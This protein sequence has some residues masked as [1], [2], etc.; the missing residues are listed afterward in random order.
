PLM[1]APQMPTDVVTDAVPQPHRALYRRFRAQRFAEVIGQDPI[2]TTLRRAIASDR[3]AHAYLFVGPRGTGKTSTARILAK[4][5]NCTALAEDG[6]PCDAC[7]SC[8]SIRD[9][10]ALDVIEIDAASHGLVEDARDLVMR[11]LTAPSELRKRVYII[12]EVHMLSTHA[13]N[14]LLKLIEEPPDHVVFIL[15]T[16]DTHK[17]PPTIISRTQRHDF[18]RLAD[19]IIAGK[20]ARIC[21]TEGVEADADALDLVARLADGGMRDAESILDQVLAYV[22]GRV[23]AAEVREAVGLADDEAI[24]A[25]VDAYVAGDAAGALGRLADLADAGRDLAQVAAQAEG[26]ARRRLLASASRPAEAARLAPILRTLA[27]AAGAGAREGRA[28]L[29][30]ELLAVESATASRA[31][32][33]PVAAAEA[34]AP[35]RAPVE[36]RPA[37]ATQTIPKPAAAPAR[38]DD[39]VAAPRAAARTTPAPAPVAEPTAGASGDLA[40]I[41]GR[42]ADVVERATPVIKPLLKECR[43]VARDGARLTLAF[44]EGRDFMRSRISQR[45]AAIEALLTEMFGGAFAIECVATNVELEP[46]TVEQAIAPSDDD[47]EA[48]ALLEGVLKITGGELVDAPEVR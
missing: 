13:F 41:R 38:P 45:S 25:L 18:R 12:D 1:P 35:A 33:A 6:E 4:A 46:L 9:G 29:L 43:P 7:P 39:G 47:P 8:T 42:W 27:E 37:A 15:A 5:I 23:T 11:A 2:V 21:A 14:A 24:V 22:A 48:R 10:R 17:V 26:E 3:L 19:A 20:L 28:R 30:M 44:P 31:A 34:P 40:A 36:I 16:T 32:P